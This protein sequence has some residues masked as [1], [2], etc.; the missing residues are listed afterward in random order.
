MKVLLTGAYKWTNDK[1]FAVRNLGFDTDFIPDERVK[2]DLDLSQYDACVCNGLFM[3]NDISD[4]TNLKFIQAT[5]AGL[6]RMPL[7]YVKEHNIKILNAKGVYSAPMAEW[8]LMRAL[9]IYKHSFRFYE[10]QKNCLW[11]KDRE[12]LE[13]SGKTVLVIGT[14]SVGT[15]V[16][17]RFLAFDA[18]VIGADIFKNESPYY[19]ESILMNDLD[20][21]LNRADIVILTLPLTEETKGL[22][23][24]EKFGKMKYNSVLINI[25]RGA[26]V[27]EN[28]LIDALNE[29]RLLGAAIDV[30]ETEPLSTENPLWKTENLLISPHNSF[31]SDKTNERL[32]EV[33]MKNLGDFIKE[34]R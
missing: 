22:F 30:F 20:T 4:F 17:K 6:D 11:E 28:A 1:I 23:N 34:S 19:N 3:Y 16:A 21:A 24:K 27:E 26:I 18:Y 25:A 13:I 8:A 2:L 5:S 9:E 32:F 29:R 31:V 7:D 12:L 33:I 10:N 14:G 15:E